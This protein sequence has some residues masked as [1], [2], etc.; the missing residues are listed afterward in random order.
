[1]FAEDHSEFR[2]PPVAMRS[3]I[4]AAV[5]TLGLIGVGHTGAQLSGAYT[6]DPLG[7]GPRN[8]TTV[9]AAVTALQAGVTGPV[10]FDLAPVVFA[11]SLRLAPVS[12]ASST[13]TITFQSLGSPAVLDPGPSPNITLLMTNGTAWF[14]LTNLRLISQ[15]QSC[16]QLLGVSSGTGV[17]DNVFTRVECDSQPTSNQYIRALYLMGARN[18]RF[19]GCTFR[20]GGRTVMIDSS[21]SNVL[22]G[23]EIDGKNIA[24]SVVSLLNVLDADNVIQNCFIHDPDRNNGT[25]LQMMMTQH[26]N[27]IFNNTILC[28]TAGWAVQ[29]GGTDRNWAV[30]I[31]FKNNIVVNLGTGIL[32]HVLYCNIPPSPS[33]TIAPC[34]SDFNCYHCPRNPKYL[35]VIGTHPATTVFQGDLAAFRAWQKTN[36]SPI[37]PGGAASYDANSLEADPG[38]VRMVAPYDVH[39]RVGSPLLD[40][41]TSR[42]VESYQS[43]DPNHRVSADFEGQ[44]RDIRVDIGCD[45]ADAVV[46]GQ[47]TPSPGGIVTLGLSSP[48]DVGLPYRAGSSFGE[49]PV[50][51]D[52][53]RLGLSHD[54]LLDVSVSGY[55]PSVFS[56]YV[57]ALDGSGSAR[58]RILIPRLQALIGARVHSAFLTLDPA[59]PSGVKSV[60]DTFS[61]SI[62]K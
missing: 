23:C 55:W 21:T 15:V 36:P 9:G 50:L 35:Q 29:V 6:I 5:L 43:F 10:T 41:G 47:G 7:S 42:F 59:A 46:V 57:G 8:F 58:A 32:V 37:W 24:T 53:R 54:G 28:D 45:E 33:N 49:G 14:R 4:G 40:R 52:R 25:A 17:H 16:L 2:E 1:M 30:A 61:F 27:M 39:L 34:V 62:S 13:N 19:L 11:E 44:A 22:D 31:G 51:I 3:R 38:L 18:N 60:S 56:G 26:G 48:A 20:G 12:G